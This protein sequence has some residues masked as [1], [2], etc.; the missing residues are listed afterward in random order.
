MYEVK[1]SIQLSNSFSDQLSDHLSDQL[2]DQSFSHLSNQL[3]AIPFRILSCLEDLCKCESR[4][5]SVF[6]L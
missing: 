5:R 2:S 1:V 3:F 4:R 6:H